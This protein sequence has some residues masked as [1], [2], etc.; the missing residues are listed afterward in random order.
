MLLKHS[1]GGPCLAHTTQSTLD[2]C[3]TV[4]V[5]QIPAAPVISVVEKTCGL[6]NSLVCYT[7]LIFTGLI[8]ICF[9]AYVY[10]I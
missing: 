3:V 6:R 9:V 10:G 2:K 7:K 5:K 4:P 8:F 1:S